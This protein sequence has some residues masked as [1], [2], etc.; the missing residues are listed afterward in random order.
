[1]KGSII[2]N[3]LR[4]SFI[5]NSFQLFSQGLLYIKKSLRGNSR[6]PFELK[7]RYF[8]YVSAEPFSSV[9]VSSLPENE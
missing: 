2:R 3:L 8:L 5:S 9:N 1:M 7:A 4:P 6:R